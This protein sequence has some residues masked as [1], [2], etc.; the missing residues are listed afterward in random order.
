MLSTDNMQLDQP[1]P[2]GTSHQPQSP[3]LRE[4]ARHRDQGALGF[5]TKKERLNV[6]LTRQKIHLFV[7]GDIT[8]CETDTTGT[9]NVDEL[10]VE[11][12]ESAFEAPKSTK[13]NPSDRKNVWVAR[14]LK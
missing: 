12:P 11:A 10:P 8:C 6:L 5:L 9:S 3:P 4:R 1:L 7:V 2:A 14:V 13:T